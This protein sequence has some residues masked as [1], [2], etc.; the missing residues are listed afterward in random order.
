MD[1]QTMNRQLFN[2]LEEI[3]KIRL[4]QNFYLRD[5]LYSE[6]AI[7]HNLINIPNDLELAIASGSELCEKILEPLQNAWGRIHIRSGYRSPQVNEFGNMNKLNCASN[8]KNYAG[9]IWDVRDKANNI[10]ATA[11]IVIPRY[12]DYFRKT[13]DWASLAWWIHHNIP[14][15]DNI[16]FFAS[17][18]AFNIRWYDT[19]NKEKT[20]KSFA[21]NPDTEDK[22]NILNKGVIHEF[23]VNKTAE[24][25]FYK[26]LNLMM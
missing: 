17:N 9:H 10:G 16:T 21:T 3:G 4:S 5:F 26:C 24:K 6:I 18:A 1:G 13:G 11:C 2:R 20:I 19:K 8:D 15:Y 25:R 7:A 12:V 23:Y 14:E 22:K